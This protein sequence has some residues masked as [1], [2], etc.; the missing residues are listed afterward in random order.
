MYEETLLPLF[1]RMGV[2]Y[3]FRLMMNFSGQNRGFAYLQYAYQAD[4]ERALLHFNAFE[5]R[6]GC[7]LRLLRSFNLRRLVLG[8]IRM[9]V[10]PDAICA[11]VNTMA[12]DVLSVQVLVYGQLQYAILQFPSHWAAAMGRRSIV[13]DIRK[14]G[15]G[16]W[17][18]WDN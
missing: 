1:S 16:S 5:V 6:A 14:F 4:A 11:G 7:R 12:S 10:H 3:Q 15:P 8:G 17:I 9:D 13:Q 2:I 18:N